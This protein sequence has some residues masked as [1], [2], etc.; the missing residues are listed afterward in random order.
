M[1]EMNMHHMAHA[2][3][4][5]KLDAVSGGKI[6]SEVI[7]DVSKKR[8]DCAR[9]KLRDGCTDEGTCYSCKYFSTAKIAR[10]GVENDTLLRC[11]YTLVQGM[12]GW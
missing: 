6:Q 10:A 7:F 8:A 3:P 1:H 2:I 11:V 12:G 4:E 5:E 9:F